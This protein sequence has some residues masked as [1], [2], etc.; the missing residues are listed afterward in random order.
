MFIK[1]IKSYNF[2]RLV[3]MSD[4]FNMYG[5]NIFDFCTIILNLSDADNYI[6]ENKR[7][8]E[9]PRLEVYKYC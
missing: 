9:I 2:K 1:I 6:V 5:I 3:L 4:T 7:F 8:K